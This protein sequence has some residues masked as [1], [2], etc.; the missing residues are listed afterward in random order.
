MEGQK[1]KNVI[2]VVKN[3]IGVIGLFL[4]L[5]EAIAALVVVN[6][7]LPYSLNLIIVLFIVIFP[8]IVLLVFYLLVTKHHKKLYSPSDFK[9]E[10]NFVNT[11]DSATQTEKIIQ[12]DPHEELEVISVK[13]GMTINDINLIKE[14][15]NTIVSM[16]KSLTEKGKGSEHAAIVER[17][18]KTINERLDS[19]VIEKEVKYKTSVSYIYGSR[20]FVKNLNRKGYLAEIYFG[21][22]GKSTQLKKNIE[23]EA[24]WLGNRVPVDFAIDIIKMAKMKFPHLKYIDL[25]PD[26]APEYVHDEIYIGGATSTALKDKLKELTSSDFT[27]LFE[28]KS[29]EEMHNLIIDFNMN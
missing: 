22:D 25:S 18:E 10:Q 24:I 23:H 27:R 19:Y 3:P 20:Q 6:S 21:A 29:V 8:F 17:A 13:E 4:V 9:D 12:V 14:S 7:S 1:V 2:G 15:L 28:C 26:Y 11:Y 16:Q 5:V